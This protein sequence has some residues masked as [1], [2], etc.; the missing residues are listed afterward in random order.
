M[1]MPPTTA[2]A[3]GLVVVWAQTAGAKPLDTTNPINQYKLDTEPA[4]PY[5]TAPPHSATYTHCVRVSLCSCA[6]QASAGGTL[7]HDWFEVAVGLYDEASTLHTCKVYRGNHMVS[8]TNDY[9]DIHTSG[10]YKLGFFAG[11]YDRT[12]F[13]VLGATLEVK[14]FQIVAS[15]PLPPPLPPSPPPTSPL[16]PSPPPLSPPP[17]SPPPPSSSPP[18]LSPPPPNSRSEFRVYSS[19][20]TANPRLPSPSSPPLSPPP[21]SPSLLPPS[22]SPLPPSPSPPPPSPP[23]P[24]SSPSPPPPLPSPPPPPF[25]NTSTPANLSTSI[26]PKAYKSLT[27][28]QGHLMILAGILLLALQGVGVGVCCYRYYRRKRHAQKV[29][30]AA[31]ETVQSARVRRVR[32]VEDEARRIRAI[33]SSVSPASTRTNSSCGRASNRLSNLASNFT[34]PVSMRSGSTTS[35]R[36]YFMRHYK[37]LTTTA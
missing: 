10:K 12:C 35:R 23:P 32:A 4:T 24:P 17:L 7:T 1:P 21:P 19:L 2:L 25:V 29:L 26:H 28:N 20:H 14:A 11:S 13:G 36:S 5:P 27:D 3:A 16:P 30:A 22:P 33:G 37:L 8:F 34:T 6:P 15:S 18:L 31:A 9:V